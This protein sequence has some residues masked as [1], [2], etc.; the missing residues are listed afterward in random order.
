[1]ATLSED[2][3]HVLIL[4]KKENE[5]VLLPDINIYVNIFVFILT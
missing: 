3:E 1:M 5:N 2:L 4:L